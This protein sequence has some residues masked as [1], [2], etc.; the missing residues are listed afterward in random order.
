MFEADP[1]LDNQRTM[2]AS[3]QKL[4]AEQLTG[5]PP[6][7]S[8]ETKICATVEQAVDHIGELTGSGGETKPTRVLVT[9]SLHLIGACLTVLNAEVV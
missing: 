3:W 2:L 4:L 8:P 1:G 6:L 5:E 7:T 9:G